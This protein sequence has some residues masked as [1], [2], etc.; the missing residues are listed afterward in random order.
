MGASHY[1]LFSAMLVGALTLPF[2]G[3]VSFNLRADPF[4]IIHKS[5]EKPAAFLGGRGLDRYTHAGVIRHYHPNAII[6]GHSHAANFLPSHVDSKLG[7]KNTYS[8]TLDGGTLFEHSAVARH[9]LASAD[10]ENI[11][12]LFTSEN[13]TKNP[14]V[15]NSKMPF[16]QFLYDDDWLNDISLFMTLPMHDYEKKKAWKR[17]KFIKLSKTENRRVDTRD[18]STSWYWD[19]KD[20]FNQPERIAQQLLGKRG[21]FTH[22]VNQLR[23][24][25]PFSEEQI[26]SLANHSTS[27]QK[28]LEHNILPVI[29]ANPSTKVSI[30]IDPPFP[31]MTWQVRKIHHRQ[32]Y[33]QHLSVINRLVNDLAKYPNVEVYGFGGEP[34][35]RDLRLYK[36]ETHYH[37]M[38]ND[39]MLNRIAKGENRLTPG[40]VLEYLA[41]FDALVTRFELPDEWKPKKV[42]GLHA[43]HRNSSKGIDGERRKPPADS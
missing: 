12:W 27:Y 19:L 5:V 20:R 39:M 26:A 14:T 9:A 30:V 10:I 43:A 35:T 36:D 18:Y 40:N 38:L 7:F 1:K 17:R 16:P 33:E 34:V 13:F 2:A 4:E 8:L 11:L 3:A 24:M 41:R 6:I 42:R 23:Q 37:L 32:R 15:T 21:Q 22:L 29:T 28:N 25:V 31:L